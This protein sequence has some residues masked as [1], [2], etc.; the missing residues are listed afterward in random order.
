MKQTEGYGACHDECEYET[1]NEC[2]P[3]PHPFQAVAIGKTL[4]ET[5]PALTPI[6]LFAVVD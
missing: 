3:L 6:S 4:W 1:A 2:A 5:S